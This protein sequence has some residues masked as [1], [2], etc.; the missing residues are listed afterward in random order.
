VRLLLVTFLIATNLT[1]AAKA[2]RM[3][4]LMLQWPS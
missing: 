2:M 4:A 1:L 3:N